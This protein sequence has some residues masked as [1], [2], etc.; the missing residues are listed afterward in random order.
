MGIKLRI[1]QTNMTAHTHS[2]FVQ[3]DATVHLV[4]QQ[5]SAVAEDLK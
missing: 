5:P 1:R 2:V 4:I 3:T